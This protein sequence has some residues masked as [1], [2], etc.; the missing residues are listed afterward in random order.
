MK[1]VLVAEIGQSA[2]V[3]SAFA[4]LDTDTP[5]FIGQVVTDLGLQE[6]LSFLEK[7]IGA[8]KTEDLECFIVSSLEQEQFRRALK[9]SDYREKGK[10][11]WEALDEISD[12]MGMLEQ[13]SK[14]VIVKPFKAIRNF[15]SI[16]LEE[17]GEV[18][19]LDSDE[20][21]V[22][23]Y[24]L[25][26]DKPLCVGEGLEVSPEVILGSRAWV[27]S[28]LK[29]KPTSTI[30]SE[31]KTVEDLAA[32]MEQIAQTL[33]EAILDFCSQGSDSSLDPGGIR[34]LTDLRW[35]IGTGNALTTLPGGAEVIRESLMHCHSVTFPEAGLP[36]LIDQ[37]N[38]LTSL[39]ALSGIYPHGA[40]LL[41]LESLGIE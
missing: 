24:L 12:P 13:W 32:Q 18:L 26:R 11:T 21:S 33:R 25:Q 7:D 19:I 37:D 1:K 15:S 39:G 4:N 34:D 10:T 41:L 31:L 27:N 17:V 9:T 5:L 40:W 23:L 38:I 6:G 30:D 28:T 36:I 16:F 8:F 35:V 29:A 14:A 22:N 20:G 3:L 2:L